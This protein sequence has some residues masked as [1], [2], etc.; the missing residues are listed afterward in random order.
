[1]LIHSFVV[2]FFRFV[3]NILTT[4]TS[5]KNN[6]TN[7]FC[8]RKKHGH[9]HTQKPNQKININP[10]SYMNFQSASI[11][12]A[13][14]VQYASELLN[15]FENSRGREDIELK[16]K[17]LLRQ[18]IPLMATFIRNMSSFRLSLNNAPFFDFFL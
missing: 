18:F 9:K 7:Y 15:Q 5:Y 10:L 3:S 4:K 6:S 11:S 12:Q 17:L 2:L 8:N 1:M 14:T 16:I 13:H